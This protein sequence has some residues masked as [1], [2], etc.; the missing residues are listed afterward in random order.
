MEKIYILTD[1]KVYTF[2]LLDAI[3]LRC[4]LMEINNRIVAAKVSRDH[5]FLWIVFSGVFS[6]PDGE[7]EREKFFLLLLL[8][9]HFIIS[10]ESGE[11]KVSRVG[12]W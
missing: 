8:N 7:M 5:F 1:T 3:S 9:V 12:K 2:L 4:V 11:K 6:T 10:I